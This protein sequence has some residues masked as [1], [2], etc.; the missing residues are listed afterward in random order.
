MHAK[1]FISLPPVSSLSLPRR[2]TFLGAPTPAVEIQP[3]ARRYTYIYRYT[4]A[5]LGHFICRVSAMAVGH[6][7]FYI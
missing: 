1:T 3:A 6:S 2:L 4:I 5:G 7:H